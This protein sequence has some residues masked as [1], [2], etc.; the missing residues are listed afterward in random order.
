MQLMWKIDILIFHARY[1]LKGLHFLVICIIFIGFIMKTGRLPL[2]QVGYHHV[3][4][5]AQVDS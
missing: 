1:K 4:T 2:K 3:T 5:F